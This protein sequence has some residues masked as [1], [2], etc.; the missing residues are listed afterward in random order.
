MN[1]NIILAC[2]EKYGIAD[3]TKQHILHSIPWNIKE[4]IQHFKKETTKG[5]KNAIIMGRKTAD[6]FIKPL[7]NRINYVITSQ[8]NYRIEEGFHSASTLDNCLEEI[9][10]CDNVFVIGGAQLFKIAIRNPHCRGIYLTMIHYDY[11][12]NIGI[13]NTFIKFFRENKKKSSKLYCYNLNKKIKVSFIYYNKDIEYIKMLNRVIDKSVKDSE[14]LTKLSGNNLN[15]VF[16]NKE[17]IEYLNLLEEIVEKGDYRKTRNG[18]TY[19]LFGK[20]LEFDL[21]N[22]LPLLT[23]K[24]MFHRGIIEEL[25]FFLRGETDTKIL[26]EKKVMIWH[27]N[28]TADFIKNNGK[29]LEEYE[30]GPMYGYQWRYFG[31]PYD[32]KE[33]GIDQLADVIDKLIKDPHSRRILLTSYNPAQVEEGVLYPCHGLTIQFYV[34]K[35]RISLQMYQRSADTFLGLP[36]NIAS[37]AILLHIVVKLVNGILKEEKYDVGRIIMV[38]GDTHVYEEHLDAI[39]EQLGRKEKTYQF[40]E[41]S[42]SGKLECLEDLDKL[43]IGDFVIEN[44]RCGGRIKAKMI[45]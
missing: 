25:L 12:C 21:A 6:T 2:D 37:Y 38:M 28:T 20:R 41:L 30:M 22:G 23:T 15:Y 9:G 1:F 39:K 11:D 44:Y 14:I 29:N 43:E 13:K 27:G 5:V 3:T 7:P 4:D 45:A 31:A 35:S 18:N 33:G 32:K 24:K 10:E 8:E 17:E 16:N 36:F 26:E 34:E 40:P 42:I 19:S